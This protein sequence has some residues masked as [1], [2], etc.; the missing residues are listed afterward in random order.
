MSTHGRTI[1]H[2]TVDQV[3]DALWTP[4]EHNR[5]LQSILDRNRTI[6]ALLARVALEHDHVEFKHGRAKMENSQLVVRESGE[7]ANGTKRKQPSTAAAELPPKSKRVV[8][9]RSKVWDHFTEL[10]NNPEK[11]SCNY[12]GAVLSG[13]SSSGTSSLKSHI[14]N[15]CKV[16]KKLVENGSQKVLVH[17]KQED[18]DTKLI[19]VGFSQ[20][21][22]RRATIKMVIM[23]ELPF[24]FVEGAGFKL[25]CSVACPSFVIPSRKVVAKEIY[26]FFLSEKASLKGLLNENKQRISLTTDI[27]TSI[28][29]VSYMVITAHFIDST[30][31]LNRKIIGFA[32][33]SNHKGET[34]ANQLERCLKDWGVDKVFTITVDSAS[35]ND[36]AIKIL[37]KRL[38]TW[39]DD[40]LVLNGDFMHMRCGA[41]ILNLIVKEGLSDMGDSVISIRNAIKYVRSSDSRLQSFRSRVRSGIFSRGSLVLDCTTRWN[42]TFLMLTSALKY[43]ET[44]R[45]MELEDKLYDDYFR[46]DDESRIGKKRNGPP[47]ENDWDNA[48]RLVRVLRVFYESTLAFSAT[49]KVTSSGC[50]NE[51]LRVESVLAT[52]MN[53][54]DHNLSTMAESMKCKYDKYWEGTE[55]INKL[56]IIASAFDPRSK[57]TFITHCFEKL[58]GKDSVKAAE[59][60]RNIMDVLRRLFDLYYTWSKASDVVESGSK[61]LSNGD[62]NLCVIP[63]DLDLDIDLEKYDNP[64]ASFSQM[65]AHGGDVEG[66]LTELDLY[67]MEKLEVVRSNNLSLEFDILLWWKINS[68]KFPILA[69]MA[70]D[71]L[72]FPVSTVAS[73]AAF[74]TGCRILD[75]YRSSLN[76]DMVEALILTQN[77]LQYPLFSDA[78]RSLKDVIAENDFMFNMVEELRGEISKDA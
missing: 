78:T 19:A 67:L 36:S 8:A 4:E 31:R 40:T 64:F 63:T 37:R 52:L 43:K 70:K 28:T 12:C 75:Q 57:M 30:W 15:T 14:V 32:P 16:Y 20:E 48:Q 7:E 22:C 6:K 21:A 51:I 18:G 27:W 46:E 69:Q 24:A 2:L 42:S 53:S 41:H 25:F 17:D 50:Y 5:G 72:A 58:Y 39:N 65:I 3:I 35:A 11:C 56:L 9:K 38:S 49:K 61:H 77:W 74:S 29:T 73:E 47:S 55:K 13:A 26:Q 10:H 68:G 45:R 33:I 66:S 59:V 71:I 23:D 1:G 76:H 44:F 54:S 60:K 62:I 34:I